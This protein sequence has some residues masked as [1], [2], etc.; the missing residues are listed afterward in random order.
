MPEQRARKR[1]S[2]RDRLRNAGNPSTSGEGGERLSAAE[3][4]AQY[5]A[6]VYAYVSRRV[7]HRELAEDITADVFAEAFQA[8]RSQRPPPFELGWLFGVARRKIIDSHRLASWHPE[9]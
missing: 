5:L 8:M 2:V 3:L 1:S 7:A 4:G 6:P 9:I